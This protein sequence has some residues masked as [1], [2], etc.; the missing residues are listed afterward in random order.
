[1]TETLA[2]EVSQKEQTLSPQALTE[3][4]AKVL[5]EKKAQN[6]ITL[7][8]RGKASFCDFLVIA[9][10]SVS[11]QVVAL[12]DHLL[13]VLKN[14]GIYATIEGEEQG[15]WVLIDAGDVVVHIFRPE[16]RE[17]YNLE[18]MWAA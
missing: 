15:D 12:G 5:D 9:S 10:G 18:K 2:F 7:D 3:M 17:R 11:R 14:Q 6:V 1:M 16:V 8:I 4:L 13:R